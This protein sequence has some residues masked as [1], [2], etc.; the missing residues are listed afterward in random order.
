MFLLFKKTGRLPKDAGAGSAKSSPSKSNTA[1]E[2]QTSMT[3]DLCA[4]ATDADQ[5]LHGRQ[6]SVLVDAATNT[7]L[8]LAPDPNSLVPWVTHRVPGYSLL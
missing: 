3:P 4:N 7:A 2:A 6:R 8:I 1:L 5:Q